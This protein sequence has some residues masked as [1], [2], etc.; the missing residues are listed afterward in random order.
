MPRRSSTGHQLRAHTPAPQSRDVAS[1]S[2]VAELLAQRLRKR[3]HM[4]L[5]IAGRSMK[6][7]E[8]GGRLREHRH[9]VATTRTLAAMASLTAMQD[10]SPK[11]V[12]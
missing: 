2:R 9:E 1:R 3:D 7:R 10:V 6:M 11:V 5:A 4:R 8:A 12:G